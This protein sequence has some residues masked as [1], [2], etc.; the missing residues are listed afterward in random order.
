MITAMNTV[1]A[2]FILVGFA[3]VAML[4]GDLRRGPF[5]PPPAVRK[6]RP[7][8]DLAPIPYPAYG[9]WTTP[10]SLVLLV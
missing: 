9:I 2:V 5:G 1:L 10:R 4:V 7:L 8:S 3:V 6:R